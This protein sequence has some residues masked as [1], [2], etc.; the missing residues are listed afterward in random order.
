VGVTA[1]ALRFWHRVSLRESPFFALR[2]ARWAVLF[3]GQ[4]DADSISTLSAVRAA[5]RSLALARLGGD[6]IKISV[7]QARYDTVAAGQ[8]IRR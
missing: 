8:R 2:M 3:G 4:D 6:P 7:M 5:E 1:F